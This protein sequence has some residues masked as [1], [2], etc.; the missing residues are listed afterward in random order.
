MTTENIAQQYN[1]FQNAFG[2]NVDQCYE[3]LIENLFS[4][5]FTKT[6]N[7]KILVASREDL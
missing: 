3:T 7:G 2:Q 4:P 6:A 1:K 5:S